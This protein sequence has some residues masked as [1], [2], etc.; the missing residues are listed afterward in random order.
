MESRLAVEHRIQ[1]IIDALEHLREQ[2]AGHLLAQHV[3][4]LEA[5]LKE[6]RM[7]LDN[8]GI[9]DSSHNRGIKHD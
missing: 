6:L 4:N 8:R 1:Q 3:A 7:Q 5:S 9:I 2:G